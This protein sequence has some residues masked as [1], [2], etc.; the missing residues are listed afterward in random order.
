M[1]NETEEEFDIIWKKIQYLANAKTV[2]TPRSKTSEKKK[3]LNAVA[4]SH[5]AL[6]AMGTTTMFQMVLHLYFI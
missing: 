1:M 6:G 3:A 5:T 4:A 2:A